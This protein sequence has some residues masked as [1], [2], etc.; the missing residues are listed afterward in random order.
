MITPNH[1][2][3]MVERRVILN[4]TKPIQEGEIKTGDELGT[5]KLSIS[6]RKVK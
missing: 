1:V 2:K 3:K 5:I 4:I 6:R